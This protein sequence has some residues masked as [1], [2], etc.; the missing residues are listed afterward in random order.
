[1]TRRS[2]KLAWLRTIADVLAYA[3]ERGVIHRDVKPRNVMI[4]SSGDRKTA[5]LRDRKARGGRRPRE[6]ADVRHRRSGGLGHACLHGAGTDARGR[7]R[8]A[9]RSIRLGRD[10]LRGAHRRAGRGRAWR[11]RT[12]SFPSSAPTYARGRAGPGVARRHHRPGA[13]APSDARFPTMRDLLDALK[14]E[15][16]GKGGSGSGEVAENRSKSAELATEGGGVSPKRDRAAAV[17]TRRRP[18]QRSC[19]AS[20]TARLWVDAPRHPYSRR[21]RVLLLL[22]LP[23]R[24]G[25]RSATSAELA[26]ISPISPAAA[27]PPPSV[28]PA[29][30]ASANPT[31]SASAETEVVHAS[32]YA[33]DHGGGCVCRWK[34]VN[35][36][37]L[38][39]PWAAGAPFLQCFDKDLHYT[40]APLSRADQSG[41]FGQPELPQSHLCRLEG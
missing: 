41:S 31:G 21:G 34:G 5:R 4:D 19:T 3:H 14:S 17:G 12:K 38:C 22:L 30:L 23:R 35:Y 7:D 27:E 26:F 36:K 16:D 18:T 11:R 25:S 28:A 1:M 9:R 10:G 13:D 32:A 2:P 15:G 37:T 40:N 24:G 20:F 33:A 8:C 6:S 29:A 39:P